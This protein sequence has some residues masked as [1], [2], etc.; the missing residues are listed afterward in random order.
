[1]TKVV[2]NHCCSK[3]EKYVTI[4]YAFSKIFK[5]YT[6]LECGSSFFNSSPKKFLNQL[7]SLSKI[8]TLK[9]PTLWYEAMFHKGKISFIAI[10]FY[11]NSMGLLEDWF[12]YFNLEF[13]Q[14]TQYTTLLC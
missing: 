13:T 9:K 11:G 14:S 6:S 5:F 8:I 4:S 3:H 2:I 7:F 1:M 12:V 10:H